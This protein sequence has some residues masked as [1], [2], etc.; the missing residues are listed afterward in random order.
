MDIGVLF[1]LIGGHTFAI[2]KYLIDN[3]LSDSKR[4][5][6]IKDTFELIWEMIALKG[7]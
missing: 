2:N 5:E 4:T 7:D 6:V 3:Q 1:T